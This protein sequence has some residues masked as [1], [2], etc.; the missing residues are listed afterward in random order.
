MFGQQ[1]QIRVVKLEHRLSNIRKISVDYNV[2]KYVGFHYFYS[3]WP[4]LSL[5]IPFQKNNSHAGL[6]LPLATYQEDFGYLQRRNSTHRSPTSMRYRCVITGSYQDWGTTS[7]ATGS[8]PAFLVLLR[9]LQQPRA[10]QTYILAHSPAQRSAY[11][12]ATTNHDT[13]VWTAD[14]SL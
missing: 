10:S 9:A 11:L 4:P 6:R 12:V 2:L 8:G 7:G 1:T 5:K 3:S 14:R 13:I